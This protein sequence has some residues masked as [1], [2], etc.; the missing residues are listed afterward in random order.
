MSAAPSLQ[1]P[2][3]SVIIPNW[4]G[5]KWLR[6][7]LPA[8]GHQT[9]H[10]FEVIVVDNGST[11]D[12][13]TYM[14][15]SHPAVRVLELGSNT[16]FAIACN[17][18]AEAALAP[19]LVFLNS[20]TAPQ[21][22]WLQSLD[23]AITNAAPDVA[24]IGSLM[25]SLADPSRIDDAGDTLSWYC[26]ARKAGHGQLRAE[27]VLDSEPFS[28]C[29]GAV[30]FRREVFQALGGFDEAFFAYLE[31]IDLGL[32]AR[33]KGWRFL[34]AP[35]AIVLHQ[36]H[37]S[38]IPQPRYVTLMTRNR[39]ALLVKNMPVSLLLRHLPRIA[40]GQFWFF[41]VYRQPL[42]SLRGYWHFLRDLPLILRQRKSSRADIKLS[43]AQTDALL[44]RDKPR[45]G[46]LDLAWRRLKRRLNRRQ[47]P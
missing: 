39:L 19:N 42:A 10:D 45:P 15:S 43:S 21:P 35:G 40:Y 6:L 3:H 4:N 36:G 46:L 5:A 23:A 8:L 28:P 24:G 2:R 44:T 11:D 16:G 29:G 14:R 38:A 9:F 18:G 25:L 27:T 33:L 31:D 30:L 37:G 32:R 41:V 26:E 17:R 12:S 47:S 34:L 1:N 20:D 13:L 7:C 22:D